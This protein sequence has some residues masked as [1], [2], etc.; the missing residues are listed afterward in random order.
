ML[1][2]AV[3]R[4]RR[5]VDMDSILELRALHYTWTKICSFRILISRATIYQRLEEAGI[6]PPESSHMSDQELD[7]ELL[8]VADGPGEE[9]ELLSSGVD[10]L[11]LPAFIIEPCSSVGYWMATARVIDSTPTW[12]VTVDNE[13]NRLVP[14][15]G[16]VSSQSPHDFA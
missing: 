1:T 12:T 5:L 4:P 7:C 15:F 8:F 3:G 13:D 6:S 16:L 14:I 9:T 10:M 2:P 11:P